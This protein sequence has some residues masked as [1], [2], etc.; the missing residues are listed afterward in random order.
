MICRRFS[1]IPGTEPWSE[2][3]AAEELSVVVV[4]VEE[5][6]DDVSPSVTELLVVTVVVEELSSDPL[7]V[8]SPAS[9]EELS[10]VV[11]FSE[12]KYRFVAICWNK[13]C[14]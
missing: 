11:D 12:P 3:I 8:D 13:Y 2:A 4:F 6:P 7:I 10:V 1:S 14:G 9:A 5:P